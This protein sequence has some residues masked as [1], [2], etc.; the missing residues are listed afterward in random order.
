MAERTITILGATGSVGRQACDVAEQTG[1]KVKMLCAGRNAAAMAELARKFCPEVCIME[2]ENAVAELR[3]SLSD[4]DVKVSCG[5]AFT[6]GVQ[7]GFCASKNHGIRDWRSVYAKAHI[8]SRL[9]VL[10]RPKLLRIDN[11]NTSP[12]SATDI[13]GIHFFASAVVLPP[14]CRRDRFSNE[15]LVQQSCE[16]IVLTSEQGV[17]FFLTSCDTA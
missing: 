6:H 16:Q 9:W 15:F 2:D 7:V 17:L 1:I 8:I 13:P 12:P 10:L 14:R 11:H 4:M 3:A 5:I